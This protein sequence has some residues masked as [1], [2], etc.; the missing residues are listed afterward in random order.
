MKLLIIVGRSCTGKTT[1][2]KELKKTVDF[3]EV[4][5]FTTRPRRVNELN[6]GDHEFITLE[7]FN[8]L[9][10][11][12]KLIDVIEYNGNYYGL[13]EESFDFTK[14]NIV[15]VEPSG[16][17]NLKEKLATRFDIIAIELDAPDEVILER[18]KMRGDDPIV[19]KK[20]FE[21]DKERFKDVDADIKLI[22]PIDIEDIK[23][24]IK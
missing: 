11:E 7:E 12:N 24:Y 4:H 2:V 1:I 16:I 6:G 20:R 19:A 3:F 9:K 10:N 5:S 23:K 8:R 18:F 15:V 17:R 22:Y 21:H 13:S 14:N